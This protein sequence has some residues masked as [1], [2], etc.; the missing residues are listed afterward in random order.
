MFTLIISSCDKFSDL[1]NDHLKLLNKH[2][3][4]VQHRT[5]LVTDKKT[6]RSFPNVEIVVTPSEYDF[7]KRIRYVL[8]FV[9]TEYVLIT[10]DDYFLISDIYESNLSKL[11][12]IAL[13]KDIDYLLLYN[14]RR[15]DPQKY[16]PIGELEKID[17][18][19]NYAVT[20][21]PALWKKNF[22]KK[23]VR[24][25][26]TPWDY[27]FSLTK[28]AREEGAKCYFSPSGSFDILDVV[29]KGKVLHKANYYLKKN[30]IQITTRKTIEYSTEMKLWL[31]DRISWYAPKSVQNVIK[32]IMNKFGM[33]FY[34]D[35]KNK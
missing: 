32:K 29:R 22:L 15:T 34:S 27:E 19:K 2:W 28:I 14:R 33:T 20:L 24:E 5:I 10:L 13:Q 23:T 12:N 26:S 6:E 9:D 30:D 11:E 18:N 17:I 35:N 31:M 3:K 25:N 21:Y 16:R 8:D 1:W 4:G 7:P